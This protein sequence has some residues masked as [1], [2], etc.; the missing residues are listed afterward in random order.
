MNLEA[1]MKRHGLS[2]LRAWAVNC[3]A[4]RELPPSERIVVQR[5]IALP[6]H[7]WGDGQLAWIRRGVAWQTA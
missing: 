3:P 7:E 4:F 6:I 1:L 5:Q 2:R